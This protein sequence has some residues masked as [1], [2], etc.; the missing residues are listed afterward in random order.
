MI[1]KAMN[2]CFPDFNAKTNEL[3][4]LNNRTFT[5]A[6]TDG[7][8]ARSYG[9]CRRLIGVRRDYDTYRVSGDGR[10][11]LAVGGALRFAVRRLT[12]RLR[13]AWSR[14][15]RGWRFSTRARTCSVSC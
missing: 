7:D 10:S 1:D 2:F 12:G 8:G 6:I 11:V 13:C 3:G 15:G 9:V 14:G 5:F 4:D